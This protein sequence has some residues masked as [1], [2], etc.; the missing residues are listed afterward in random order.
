MTQPLPAL[1]DLHA[2]RP[3]IYWADLLLSATLGWAA[4]AVAAA[5]P[6]GSP[7]GIAS[8]VVAVFALYRAVAFTHEISHQRHRL[9]G[10]EAAWNA[11][12]G[13]PLLLPSFTYA[14]VHFDNHRVATYGTRNDP[15]YLPFARSAALTTVYILQ[16]LIIPAL[17]VIRF[18]LLAP[19]GLFSRRF[20]IWLIEHASAI[21]INRAYRRTAS[22]ALIRVVRRD[23][24]LLLAMWTILIGL[25][26]LAHNP[27]AWAAV[28]GKGHAPIVDAFIPVRAAVLWYL[29]MAAINV[30][31]GLR[32]LAAHSYESSGEPMDKA[33]QTA[34]SHDIPGSLLTELWAPVGLRYH[35]THHAF[36]GIPYHALP[37]AFRRLS[38]AMP[39]SYG[40]MTQP[41]LLRTLWALYRKG[42]RAA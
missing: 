20:E 40:K 12:A 28:F 22:A 39:D 11:L 27:E 26:F 18:L 38:A 41:G 25:G 34:D 24:W 9:P 23:T 16:A 36:P 8:A 32:T 33:A 29:L 31:D 21:T 2:V 30:I 13:F 14:Q 17:L 5:E 3:A 6:L 4:F 19:I 15:E 35:A 1:T 37:R 42:M 10:F 7:I